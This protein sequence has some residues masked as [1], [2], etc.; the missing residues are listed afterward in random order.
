MPKRV[1]KLKRPISQVVVVP[2]NHVN[3]D[4][5]MPPETIPQTVI[6]EPPAPPSLPENAVILTEDELQQ[7]RDAAYQ[8][9]LR[10][11]E[12][13]GFQNATEQLRQSLD[14]LSGLVEHITQHQAHIF[15]HSESYCLELIFA[16]TEKIVGVLSDQQKNLV[17]E[18]LRRVLKEA[19]ISGKVKILV[20]PQNLA[21]IRS[22][23]GELRQTLPDLK[24]LGLVA[25]ESIAPGGCVIETG[26]G[27]VDARIN[28]Q[29]NEMVDKLRKLF[30]ELEADDE[31]PPLEE[32][33]VAGTGF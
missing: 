4:Q 7:E 15:T 11:G 3:P 13:F 28:T 10:D 26:L 5:A 22:I 12:A 19:E 6:E 24:E 16:M 8:Q 14:M 9:G 23:E 25:D 2:A 33:A 32:G 29:L 21:D 30:H 20:H 31:P 18:V 27:K 17:Q 1:I